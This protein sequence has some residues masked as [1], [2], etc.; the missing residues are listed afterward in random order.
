MKCKTCGDNKTVPIGRYQ[1]LTGPE[2]D[3]KTCGGT[4]VMPEQGFDGLTTEDIVR[5][6]SEYPGRVDELLRGKRLAGPTPPVIHVEVEQDMAG[7]TVIRERQDSQD[8]ICAW[9]REGRIEVFTDGEHDPGPTVWMSPDD[10][11][12]FGRWLIARAQELRSR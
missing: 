1:P 9:A 3:C 8:A 2:E 6:L 4:G 11:E 7:N 12:A 5:I 10:A